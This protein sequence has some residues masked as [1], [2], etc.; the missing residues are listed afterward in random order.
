[1]CHGGAA[2]RGLGRANLGAGF[3]PEALQ[4]GGDSYPETL[5]WIADKVA[6]LAP[7]AA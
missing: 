7:L 1:M 2:Q 5:G 4:L 3:T 6:E